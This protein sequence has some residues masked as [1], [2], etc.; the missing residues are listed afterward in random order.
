MTTR[1]T[2][3]NLKK[4]LEEIAGSWNGKESG[5]LEDRANASIEGI[6]AINTLNLILE[7]LNL[8]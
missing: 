2:L 6:S 4:K 7:E 3:E 8:D 1:E 5:L